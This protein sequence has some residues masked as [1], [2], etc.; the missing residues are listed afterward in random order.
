MCVCGVCKAEVVVVEVVGWQ[1]GVQ[2]GKVVREVWWC[3]GEVEG[4]GGVREVVVV[5]CVQVCVGVGAGKN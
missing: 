3:V 2:E 5:V 4:R 1:R